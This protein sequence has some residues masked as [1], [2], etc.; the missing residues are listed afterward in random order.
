MTVIQIILVAFSAFALFGVVSRFRRGDLTLTRLCL[1]IVFWAA[2]IFVT[3]RPDTTSRL[4][5]RLGVGRGADVA[6]YLALV[7]AFYLL[8]RLYVKIEEVERQITKLT[9]ETA[10]KDLDREHHGE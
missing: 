5:T 10:L 8:F 9:R 7:A 6:V 2:V 3:L 1:W 4:A